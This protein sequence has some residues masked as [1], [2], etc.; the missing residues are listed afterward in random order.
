LCVFGIYSGYNT[1][2]SLMP[3]TRAAAAQAILA[4]RFPDAFPHRGWSRGTIATGITGL[5]AILPDGG[6]QRGRLAVWSPGPGAAALLRTTCQRVVA[7]GE[8]SV[9]IDVAHTITGACWQEG[10]LLIRPDMPV[11]G[12]RAAEELARS[13]GFALVA[14][15]GADPDTTAMVRL[16]RA[17]HEGGSALVLL[18]RTTALASLRLAS[19]PLPAEYAWHRSPLGEPSSVTAVK[20]RVEARASGWFASTE[21]LIPVKYDEQRLAPDYHNPDRRGSESRQRLKAKR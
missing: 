11:A 5:D 19:R 13:G 10:P 21:L 9:W 2:T 17:V 18:T 4:Q 16:S 20:L 8:R 12:L 15:D 6:F 7:E 1:A 14:L 3:S